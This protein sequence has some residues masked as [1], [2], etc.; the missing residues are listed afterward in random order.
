M[1]VALFT[2]HR[3]DNASPF[4]NGAPFAECFKEMTVN[5]Y[6]NMHIALRKQPQVNVAAGLKGTRYTRNALPQ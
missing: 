4:E 3:N 2:S 6:A 5:I 1:H